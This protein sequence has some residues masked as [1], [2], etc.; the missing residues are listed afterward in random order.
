VFGLGVDDLQELAHAMLDC[1]DDVGF[2]LR[3]RV[4]HTNQVLAVVVLLLHLLVQTVVD[5]AL[6]NVGVVG[7]LHVAAVRVEDCGVLTKKLNVLLGVLASLVDSLTAL[8]GSLC[9]LLALVLDLGVQAVE[10]GEN[11]A[12]QLLRSLVVL[13]GDTL[14]WL[15][16]SSGS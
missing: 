2:E 15:E 5:S 3:E 16:E 6:E 12:F 9:E 14:T 13:V 8:A 10:D 11:G 1:L 4:L 7:S